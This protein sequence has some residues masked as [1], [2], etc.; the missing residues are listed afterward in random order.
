MHEGNR[1]LLLMGAWFGLFA[2]WMLLGV[3]I[4][5][6]RWYT[7][8]RENERRLGKLEQ[9][10]ASLTLCAFALSLVLKAYQ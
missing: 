4:P 7:G 6:L 1:S 3:F 8:K 5:R 2:L 9:L 10:I